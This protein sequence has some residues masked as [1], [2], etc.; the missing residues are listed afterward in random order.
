MYSFYYG[1]LKIR[2]RNRCS[3][4]LTDTDSPCCEIQTGDL[5]ADM[6]DSLDLYDTGNFAREHPQYSES[7]HGVLGKFKSEMGS[8]PPVEFIGLRAKMYSL[9]ALKKK[10]YTK[11]EGLQKHFVQKNFTSRTL[12]TL[13]KNIAIECTR[14]HACARA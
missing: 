5:Y 3:L 2:Y 12:S 6:D 14:A 4:V 9:L 8:I 11:V 7:N 10:S 1:Y 13:G